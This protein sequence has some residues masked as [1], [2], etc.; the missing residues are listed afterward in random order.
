MKFVF[1]GPSGG[2]KGTFAEIFK[3]KGIQ[4][5]ISHTTRS[6]RDGEKEGVDY[7]FLEQKRLLQRARDRL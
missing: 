5:A 7:F 4:K 3:D 2:G 6:M 1:I